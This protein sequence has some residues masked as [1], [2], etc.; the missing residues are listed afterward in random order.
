MTTTLIPLSGIEGVNYNTTYTAYDQTAAISSTNSPDNPGP[1][2]TVGTV[3]KSTGG[4]EFIFVKAGS[5][6]AVGDC[7]II[8]PTTHTALG[9]TIALAA[10]SEGWQLGFAQVAIANGSYGW[11]QRDGACQ[12]ISVAAG[13]VGGAPLLFTTTA[14]VLDD[15]GTGTIAG[16]TIT[17]TTTPAA[18]VPGSI[19]RPYAPIA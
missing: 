1:P 16:V 13:A 14:G 6:L 2:F 5:A 15:A 7:G 18:A 11:L 3:S 8:T 19:N 17:T 10:T 9:S 12:N 4:G